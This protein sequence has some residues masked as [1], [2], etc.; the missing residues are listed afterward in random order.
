M[1]S[2]KKSKSDLIAEDISSVV[3]GMQDAGIQVEAYNISKAQYRK[4]GGKFSEWELTKQGGFTG[5][6]NAYFEYKTPKDYPQIEDMKGIKKEYKKLLELYGSE[7]R[8]FGKLREAVE[9]LPKLK[10]EPYKPKNKNAKI[11]RHVNLVL[12][13]L[14]IG[15]DINPKETG[16]SFSKAEEARCLAGIVKNV[17]DYKRDHRDDTELNVMILGDIIENELHD[18]TSADLIHIQVCRAMYLLSQAITQFSAN[19]RKVN[20]Y[21]SVGNHGRDT[22][23][24]KGRASALK[25][26]ATETD[27]YFALRLAGQYLKNVHFHQPLTP[28]VEFK[29]FGH[30]YY[31]THGDT[32]L[33]PGNVGSKLDVKS[34]EQQAD[35]INASLRDRDE[36]KVFICGHVHVPLQTMLNNG[37]FLIVNGALTPPNTFAQSLNIMENPQTQVMWESTE[38]NAVG[39]FRIIIVNQCALKPELEQIIKPFKELDAEL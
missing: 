35:K 38:K 17:C 30:R 7:D 23:V 34:I 8:Y 14:H 9:A 29:S 25:F 37:A 1:S 28:W 15:S 16:H 21:F 39:D 24:H 13:D 22:A 20:V 6:R 10:V 11:E 26:N 3:S 32:H 5:V 19:F 2:K 36:Y 27:I 33:N 18:R 4:N 31:A 12:S